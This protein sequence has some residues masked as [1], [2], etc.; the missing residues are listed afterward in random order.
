M[1]YAKKV[2][3]RIGYEPPS[4]LM[5]ALI[6]ALK[7]EAGKMSSSAQA[8]TKIMFSD[9]SDTVE[10]KI[11]GGDLPGGDDPANNGIMSMF[12][13]IVFPFRRLSSSTNLEIRLESGLSRLYGD[14]DDL[15]QD[16]AKGLVNMESLGCVLSREINHIMEPTREEYATNT[17]WRLAEEQGYDMVDITKMRV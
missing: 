8:D 4:Y 9:S 1:D 5:A 14:Y 13:H 17:K 12:E 7:L 10:E 2:L 16:V 6:P 3:P 15:K 11:A